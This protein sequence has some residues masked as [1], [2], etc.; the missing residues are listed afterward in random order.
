VVEN[1][2]LQ[3]VQI[4]VSGLQNELLQ[5]ESQ[6][7]LGR[8]APEGDNTNPVLQLLQIPVKTSQ[9]WPTGEHRVLQ[10]YVFWQTPVGVARN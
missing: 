7:C 6:L 1:P 5:F 10:V 8:Q 2:V 4:P 3:R 9:D